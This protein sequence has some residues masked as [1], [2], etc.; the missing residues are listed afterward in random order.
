MR[1][2]R[3][4]WRR[5]RPATL[6]R[7]PGRERQLEDADRA[8]ATGVCRPRWWSRDPRIAA[9]LALAGVAAYEVPM[10]A[11]VTGQFAG[12]ALSITLQ[13]DDQL[14]IECV[15]TKVWLNGAP[16]LPDLPCV[17]VQRVNITGGAGDNVI[18][19]SSL[20]AALFPNLT[21]TTVDGGAGHDTLT[22]TG[23]TSV[24]LTDTRLE[25]TGEAPE[26]LIAIERASLTGGGGNDKIDATAFSGSVILNGGAGN[27]V[28]LG[29][30]SPDVISG[31]TGNDTIT[32]GG[33]ADSIL[34]NDGHDR[35]NGGDG[36]DTIQGGL[37]DD[38]IDGGPGRNLVREVAAPSDTTPVNYTV[39]TSAMTGFGA[40]TL[41]GV[42]DV[43][44][45]GNGGPN[46]IDFSAFAGGSTRAFG[47]GGNDLI[48][49][50]TR[51][52]LLSAIRTADGGAGNDTIVGGAGDESLAGGTGNDSVDGAGGTNTLTEVGPGG[53][54]LTPLDLSSYT[55]SGS[56]TDFFTRI[57][58]LSL[59]GGVD[60]DI[61][62]A[63]AFRGPVTLIGG[64]GND[65]LRGTPFDDQFF[66]QGADTCVG[67]SGTDYVFID[68]V[69]TATIVQLT[70]QA[71]TVDGVATRLENIETADVFAVDAIGAL[72][73]D[74]SAF[75]GSV[76][77]FGGLRNDT[78]IGGK[79]K[80]YLYGGAGNDVID[81]GP[82]FDHIQVFLP[83]AGPGPVKPEELP[84]ATATSNTLT[85]Q[86]TDT[87]TNIEAAYV[88]GSND[89]DLF[90]AS[91]FPG[92]VVALGNGGDDTLIGGPA[93]DQLYGMDGNDSLIGGRG[94]DLLDGGSGVNTLLGGDGNDFFTVQ[95]SAR[96][97]IDAGSGEDVLNVNR[98]GQTVEENATGLAAN[99]QQIVTFVG[100]PELIAYDGA[101]GS[102]TYQAAE[103]AT[104]AFFD[105]D[106][107]IANPNLDAVQADITFQRPDGTR[108]QQLL[109]M[110]P[111]SRTTIAV[112]GVPGLESTPVASVVRVPG[113]QPLLVERTMRWDASGY[114]AHGTRAADLPSQRWYFAEGSQGFFDTFVLLGN[115]NAVAAPVTVRFVRES[116]AV[117]TRQFTIP[118]FG[119]LTV[120]AGSIP[121]LVGQSFAIDLVSAIPVF[122][123]RA[124]YFGA[125]RF[126]EGGHATLGSRATSRSWY[127]AEGATGSFFDTYLLVYNPQEVPA[128]VTFTFLLES[129]QRVTR[130][131]VVAPTSR[132]T[133]N[134]ESED[135]QLANA[136]VA[137]LVFSDV[138]I[139]SER[140]MYWPGTPATWHEAHND[141]GGEAAGVRWG[142]AE[143][144]VG[145][146]AQHDTYLLIA[147]PSDIDAAN[148]TITFLRTSGAPL[149]RTFTVAAGAR[150]N[151][152]VASLVPELI[153]QSFGAVVT[154]TNGIPIVVERS[155]YWN[156]GGLTWAAGTNAG[157][158]RLQ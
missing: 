115:S 116:G 137:T 48:R 112:D 57:H 46:V 58:H 42:A 96:N 144:R 80:D 110:A 113:G 97:S 132:L 122:A 72:R 73:V 119:R 133:I 22:A 43:T 87:F 127:H 136:A 53:F 38:A 92:V 54:T 29:T 152:R 4:S 102:R 67:G 120:W 24:V 143:G 25:S 59:E 76:R 2:I 117:T 7:P 81:G 79:G 135:P 125:S 15:A 52:S 126:W 1:S 138:P 124:M 75:T 83:S 69:D 153:D 141:M 60:N 82:D 31:G 55:L 50:P 65:V 70:D 85:G 37:G 61:I 74:A 118:P 68:V 47:Q 128:V 99:G 32:A 121:E 23:I 130:T 21:A 35:L 142:V 157:A 27:D 14:V 71:A 12:G 39:T 20:N 89:G 64:E 100:K 44:V 8:R 19:V 155:M 63:S 98:E 11:A 131:K 56:G 86:G 13:N 146:P 10:P 109:T 150:F 16:F 93:D 104:G 94:A 140:S 114:G 34:G 66:A 62:D 129:G 9:L 45:I 103:G 111:Q 84:R 28:L 41:T 139:V 123:E 105:L 148:V 151:V 147:N 17:Q 30:A 107:A 95:A 101:G 108:I 88:E 134:V 149:T 77:L 154:S 18:D 90:D 36:D 6:S 26:T 145:G 5:R 106:L 158:V 49:L 40:D 78:L 51:A 156:A 3:G 33:G 91:A